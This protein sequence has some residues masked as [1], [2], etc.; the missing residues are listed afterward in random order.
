MTSALAHRPPSI[1]LDAALYRVCGLIRAERNVEKINAICLRLQE[2]LEAHGHSAAQVAAELR[3]QYDSATAA[4]EWID[5]F[6]EREL[7]SY[8]KSATV[9]VSVPRPEANTKIQDAQT[10]L[11][12]DRIKRSESPAALTNGPDVILARSQKSLFIVAQSHE[13]TAD[14]LRSLMLQ[15]LAVQKQ[16][17]FKVIDLGLNSWLGFQCDAGLVTYASMG[18]LNDLIST[19]ESIRQVWAFYETRMKQLKGAIRAYQAK[20]PANPVCLVINRWSLLHSWAKSCDVGAYLSL[21]KASGIAEPLEPMTALRYVAFMATA[22]RNAGVTCLIGDQASVFKTGGLDEAI[23]SMSLVA[24]GS[25]A[26]GYGPVA[27]LLENKQIFPSLDVR[28]SLRTH[29]EQIRAGDRAVALSNHGTGFA[30]ELPD[31][32][33]LRERTAVPLYKHDVAKAVGR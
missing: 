29:F 6:A 12:P 15:T 31:Y 8:E 30:S 24:L 10:V 1:G 28:N 7:F 21:A 19:V 16:T 20:P 33:A 3:K 26:D 18:V 9:A 2:Y 27:S 22:D 11:Q 17:Q 13:T 4:Q 23:A 32:R 5:W 25:V 14:L